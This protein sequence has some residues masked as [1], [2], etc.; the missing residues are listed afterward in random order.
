MQQSPLPED[1]MVT[2]DKLSRGALIITNLSEDDGL[3]LKEE[4][5]ERRKRL[6][7]IGIDRTNDVCYGSVLI[8]TRMHYSTTMPTEYIATQY[9][10]AQK[11]YPAFLVYDSYVDCG[12]IFAIPM[13]KLLAG[14]YYGV[15]NDADEKGIFDVLETT[16]TLS[17]K[18]KKRFGIRRR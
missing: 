6:I 14:E 8:N 10:L 13:S 18:I 11:F 5:T 3:K 12:Q 1:R 2:E 15:L 16:T 7:I 17:T 9:L 4:Q